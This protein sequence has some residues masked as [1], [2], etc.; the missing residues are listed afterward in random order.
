[1]LVILFNNYFCYRSILFNY[2][3]KNNNIELCF[4]LV[5]RPAFHSSKGVF[6]TQ[7]LRAEKMGNGKAVRPG[8][9]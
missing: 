1:M 9:T 3:K 5:N 4:L 8:G 7:T 2:C 6:R